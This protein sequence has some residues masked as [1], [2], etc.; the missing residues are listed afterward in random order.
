MKHFSVVKDIPNQRMET[1]CLV[2]SQKNEK[3]EQNVGLSWS[4]FSVSGD[5]SNRRTGSKCFL[6]SPKHEKLEQNVGMS[7]S[8]FSVLV[9]IS[10][11]KTE[12]KCFV[13]SQ[14]NEKLNQNVGLTW[15]IFQLKRAFQT[16]ERNLHVF[17]RVQKTK[18]TCKLCSN[19]FHKRREIAAFTDRWIA[20][21]INDCERPLI[22]LLSHL[23]VLSWHF[24]EIRSWL[25]KDL[26]QV[27]V[28]IENSGFK[29]IRRSKPCYTYRHKKQFCCKETCGLWLV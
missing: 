29:F 28:A 18:N 22:K 6:K 3:L 27:C 17:W 7:W 10:N 5:I 21:T 19:F 16:K 1:K 11:Q 14:K 13:M 23:K 12:S 25:V 8:T 9:G 4:T 24:V 15:S 2:M 26:H 20:Q